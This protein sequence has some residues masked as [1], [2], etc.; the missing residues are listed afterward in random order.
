MIAQRAEDL[1]QEALRELKEP[2]RSGSA[3]VNLTVLASQSRGVPS[4]LAQRAALL[5]R[6]RLAWALA[7]LVPDHERLAADAERLGPAAL[8]E[9]L[10]ELA[11]QLEPVPPLARGA[12][13]LDNLDA[14]LQVAYP[15]YGLPSRSD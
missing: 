7:L 10:E 1:A 15:S 8:S 3:L 5:L 12:I 6:E 13:L 4:E 2:P 14:A 9:H 11:A